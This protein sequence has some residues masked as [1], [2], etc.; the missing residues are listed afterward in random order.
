MLSLSA[1]SGITPG[2]CGIFYFNPQQ[3]DARTHSWNLTLEKEVMNNTVARIRYLGNH[4]NN[5]FQQYSINDAI[6]SYVWY[7][8]KG[9]PL[10]TGATSNIARRLYDN[11]SGYGGLTTYMLT[12]WNNN[13]GL[14]LEMER[15]FA[16][17]L[18][19]HISYDLLNAFAS[20]SCNS[21]CAIGTAVLRDPGYYMP[22][23]VPTDYDE[24]N[25]Y[26]NYQRATDV[27]K[28]RLKWNFLIDLPV[29]KNKKLLGNANKVLDKIRRRLAVGRK[30]FPAQHVVLAAD[31]QLEFHGRAGAQLRL[32]V[33]DP[34][35]HQRRLRPGLPVVERIY[36]GKQDQQPRRQRQPERLYGH[37]GR[38]QAGGDAVDSLGQHR[39]AGQC[40]G[41]H[42]RLHLLGH[43]HR[44]DP[45]E[46]WHHRAHVGLHW[47]AQPVQESMEAGSSAV[48]PGR[49]AV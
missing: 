7:E 37:P 35:L 30:R 41:R 36:P 24:R 28:H 47:R 17:G 29:G 31:G 18:A 19:F 2:C 21:G 45:A 32:P 43:Q 20:T 23:S 3:P 34:E 12:G 15:R 38:L 16:K 49:F 6:P 42:Q 4:T 13:Q 25:R 39:D 10:P 1:A 48:G 5:L 26:L 33:P 9:T 8:T 14:E 27:P 44:L 46:G 40:A 22:G 11:T